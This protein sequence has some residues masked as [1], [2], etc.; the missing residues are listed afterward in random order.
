[1]AMTEPSPEADA[2][3]LQTKAVKKGNKYY[4][5]GSKTFITNGP[6]ADVFQWFTPVR[7]KRKTD[8]DL[9]CRK[10]FPWIQGGETPP[11]A[12]YARI[13]DFGTRL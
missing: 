9:Y 6:K 5:T 13:A 4:L 8:L 10:V 7:A 11:Q 2:L 1:M 12:G 3:G